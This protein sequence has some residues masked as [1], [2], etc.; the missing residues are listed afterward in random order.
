MP[1]LPE[2]ANIA[3]GCPCNSGR[4]VNHG[5]VLKDTCTCITCDPAQ[6]GSVR[7]PEKC[8]WCPVEVRDLHACAFNACLAVE[9]AF[10]LG[11]EYY[12][13]AV[14]KIADLREALN[15]YQP[16]ADAH[17]RHSGYPEYGTK[18]DE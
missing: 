7:K 10:E 15:K 11:A 5:L 9:Q 13:R 14:R 16:L 4:G 1:L 12:P 8:I 3:D 2:N 6:T 18:K 17:F